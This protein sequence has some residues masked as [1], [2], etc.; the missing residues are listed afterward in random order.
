MPQIP[1]PEVSDSD[2]GAFEAAAAKFSDAADPLPSEV[3]S[4]VSR[5]DAVSRYVQANKWG[6]VSLTTTNGK[7]THSDT[8]TAAEAAALGSELLAA[9]CAAKTAT[10]AQ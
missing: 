9:A 10:R 2:F 8:M 5:A 1:Q 6:E 7:F 4:R 3:F